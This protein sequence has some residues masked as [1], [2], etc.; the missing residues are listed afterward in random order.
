MELMLVLVEGLFDAVSMKE[1]V[2]YNFLYIYT[3]PNW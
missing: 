2:R 1:T 3:Y